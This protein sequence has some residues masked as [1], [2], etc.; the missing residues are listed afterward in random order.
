MCPKYLYMDLSEYILQLNRSLPLSLLLILY[1]DKNSPHGPMVKMCFHFRNGWPSRM[2]PSDSL[3]RS[4]NAWTLLRGPCTGTW[5]WR[6]TGTCSPWVRITSLWSWDLSLGIFAFSLTC[7][8][9]APALL[10]WAQSPVDSDMKSFIMWREDFKL[11]FLH[12]ICPCYDT[13]R[14]V[15]ELK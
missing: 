4:G 5:C 12:V 11:A 8:L 10:D 3:R 2:W 9:G 7:L 13:S 6:P 14:V 15:P 1:A